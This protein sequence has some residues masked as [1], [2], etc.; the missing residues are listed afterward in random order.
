MPLNGRLARRNRVA[1]GWAN[2]GEWFPGLLPPRHTAK[3]DH[4]GK[5]GKAVRGAAAAALD[6]DRLREGGL[7]RKGVA[8][9]LLDRRPT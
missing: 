3:V 1:S 7:I 4:C 2:H 5:D 9:D 8:G 6:S